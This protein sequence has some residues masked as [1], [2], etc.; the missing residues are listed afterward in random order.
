MEISSSVHFFEKSNCFIFHYG[1]E[2]GPADWLYIE[3][4][5]EG[6]VKM[7]SNFLTWYNH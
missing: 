3:D 7:N 1:H 5:E 4:K 6:T 2:A